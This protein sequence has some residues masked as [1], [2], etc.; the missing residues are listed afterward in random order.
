MKHLFILSIL[1]SVTACGGIQAVGTIK[2]VNDSKVAAFEQ[3]LCGTISAPALTRRYAGDSALIKA[4]AK[5][6][7]EVRERFPVV[8]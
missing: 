6:C 7:K 1:L 8:Q 2:T 3:S 4:H 5:Y